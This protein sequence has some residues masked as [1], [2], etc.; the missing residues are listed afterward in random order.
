MKILIIED[1]PRAANQLQNMLATCGFSYELVAV[2]DSIEDAVSWFQTNKMPDLVFMDIQLADGL[3]FEI[4]QKVEVEAPIIFTTAFDQYAI[5]AFK[6]NSVDYL[7]K[8]IQEADLE[9]A[10]QKFEKSNQKSTVEPAILKQ[11]LASIQTQTETKNTSN[12][13]GLLVKEGNG[14]VQI[15]T[16]DLLYVYS[17]ES[18]TF[19]VTTSKRYIIDETI[20][21]LFNSLHQEEFYKINRGQIVAKRAIEKIHPYFNHRV[22]LSVSQGRDQEFI[23][24]RQKT[25]DFKSW[26]NR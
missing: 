20:D 10:L 13:S 8:P 9:V 21:Q 7:L 11:L 22:K 14:F 1:E 26:M 23:V 5:Q 6:V 15:K 16:S 19:G 25:S 12:R 4:F 17:E 18:I 24:S 3:S 2:I